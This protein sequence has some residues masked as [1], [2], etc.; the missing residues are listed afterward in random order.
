MK[1]AYD[2]LVIGGGPA[3][4]MAAKAAAEAGLSVLLVEK[5]PAIGVPVRCA[6][7]IVTSDLTRFARPDPKWVSA[8]IRRA[9]FVGPEWRSFTI[10]G[11]TQGEVLGY[12]LDRKGFDRA[13]VAE[14]AE[15][16]ASVEVHARAVPYLEEGVLAGA[17]V[18]QHGVSRTVRAKVVIAADGVESTFARRV[19]ID[20]TVPLAELDSC[21]EYVIA[22]IDIDPE[23]N[24]F[25]WS[26]ADAPRGYIWV[27]PKGPRTANVGIGISGAMSGEGHRAKDYL[28]RYV[29]RNFPNGKVTELIAG[30]VPVSRPLACTVAD[31]LIVCGDAARLS[32][33]FT[34]GGIYQALYS[35]KLAGETAAA[36]VAA[37]DW[38]KKALM[39]YDTT[40]RKGEVGKL[41]SRSYLIR[42]I[43]FRMDDAML[44]AVIGAVPDLRLSHVTVPEVLMAILKSNPWLAVKFPGLLLRHG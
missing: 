5:R 43:F 14:A 19:G 21:A 32:D 1:D 28:D 31:G 18:I 11:A 15:A 40:W 26:C 9:M 8:V 44:A 39:I 2:V 22:D 37:G 35:G 12:T 3:G 17:V 30:G 10:S 36:A 41:L 4:A 29:E 6:E 20:T 16:G 27:F 25:Y 23:M 24:V 38:S 13:L 42:D 33:P 7:G 34:G